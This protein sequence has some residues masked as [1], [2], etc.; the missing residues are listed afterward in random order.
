[1]SLAP[2]SHQRTWFG[3]F[4]S[5][6]RKKE[7]Y[8]LTAYVRLLC[9]KAARPSHT[10]PPWVIQGHPFGQ[11]HALLYFQKRWE[12][13]YPRSVMSGDERDAMDMCARFWKL[14]SIY[15]S[16]SVLPGHVPFRHLWT[17]PLL[18]RKALSA[19][20]HKIWRNEAFLPVFTVVC[21]SFQRRQEDGGLLLTSRSSTH[22]WKFPISRWRLQKAYNDLCFEKPG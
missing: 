12:L 19:L 18:K 3:A 22:S 9:H 16:G 5:W 7:A 11:L 8:I 6:L 1:M 17:G 10:H 21:S 20:V 2:S 14:V 15:V 13:D 4:L